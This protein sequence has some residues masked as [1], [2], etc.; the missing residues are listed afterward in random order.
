[1]FNQKLW[2][3]LLAGILTCLDYT[4]SA[5][6]STQSSEPISSLDKRIDTGRLVDIG[7]GRQMYIMCQGS[8][9]PT[10]VLVSGR[11]DSADIWSAVS[12]SAKP[13]PSV[14]EG[15]CA[16]TRVCAYDRPGTFTIT[17]LDIVRIGRSTVV[18]QPTSP[19]DGV[20][21]LHD[22]LAAAEVPG[23]Y[24]LVGHS[25]G[26]LIVRLFAS[27]YP[28]EVAGMVLVDTL[29]EMLYDELTP[30]QQTMWKRLNSNY[31]PVLDRYTIQ[32]RT[33]FDPSFAQMHAAPAVKIMPVEVIT[34]DQPYDF[35]G[36]ITKGILPAD[37][38]LDF[39][40]IVFKA[41]LIA[42]KKLTQLLQGK[43]ITDTHAGHY[44]HTEQP[45]MVIDAIREVVDKVR[46]SKK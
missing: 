10:V 29:T 39:G 11:S 14:F 9:S 12:D 19:K 6:E 33:D 40:P 37:T 26:G 16:F 20:Q 15:V 4:A 23:P 27:T 22:L 3:M 18:F 32:E 34:S 1:M 2:M 36:L 38:Q 30:E 45:Q 5:T 28:D 46:V 35:S 25:F 13:R 8:G 42:Q 31:S 21:N 43:Q 7:K 24:V 44:I 41:H 17:K